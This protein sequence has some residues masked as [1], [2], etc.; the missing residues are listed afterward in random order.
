MSAPKKLMHPDG[1][2]CTNPTLLRW[3]VWFQEAWCRERGELARDMYARGK[4]LEQLRGDAFDPFAVQRVCGEANAIGQ[5]VMSRRAHAQRVA[6]AHGVPW[7]ADDG[8]QPAETCQAR[9]GDLVLSRSDEPNYWS[10]AVQREQQGL[11]AATIRF[12]FGVVGSASRGG[13]IKSVQEIGWG[14]ELLDQRAVPMTAQRA[15]LMP[16]A[17]VDMDGALRAAKAHH[18]P[19]HPGQPMPFESFEE[20]L[21]AV[22]PYLRGESA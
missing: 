9:K 4:A 18:Y 3:W 10:V 13:L 14:D 1:Q 11:P 7:P 20:A 16:R 2:C 5:A 6:A 22:R 12:T 17:W 15:W 8:W 19:N 21:A